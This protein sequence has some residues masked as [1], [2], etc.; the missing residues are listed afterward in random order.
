[1]IYYLIERANLLKGGGAKPKGL[2]PL[3]EAKTARPP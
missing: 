3:K 2:K 1:M